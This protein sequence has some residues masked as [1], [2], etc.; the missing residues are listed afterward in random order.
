L[1]SLKKYILDELAVSMLVLASML[2]PMAF[3][4]CA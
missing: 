2:V 3:G 1:G 4:A